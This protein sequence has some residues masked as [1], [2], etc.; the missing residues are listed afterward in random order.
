M[1]KTSRAVAIIAGLALIAGVIAYLR[2]FDASGLA[3]KDIDTAI[4]DVNAQYEQA[5]AKGVEVYR[6]QKAIID[7]T[8]S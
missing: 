6:D 4:A 8:L 3:C 1:G 5:R 7:D 2:N